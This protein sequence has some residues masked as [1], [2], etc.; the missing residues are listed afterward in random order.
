MAGKRSVKKTAK[1]KTPPKGP[2][3]ATA[4]SVAKLEKRLGEIEDAIKETLAQLQ[5]GVDEAVMKGLGQAGKEFKRQAQEASAMF[6]KLNEDAGKP[7]SREEKFLA[8]IP[9]HLSCDHH[10]VCEGGDD[11]ER[12]EFKAWATE[13]VETLGFKVDSK[14]LQRPGDVRRGS[15]PHHQ[16]RVYRPN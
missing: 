9:R 2:K 7:M 4:A 12:A 14:S 8:S 3:M 16:L 1:K 5:A 15:L 10:V 13:L 6:A 11:A